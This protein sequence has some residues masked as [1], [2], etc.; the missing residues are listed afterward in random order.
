MIHIL[1]HDIYD[2]IHV[3]R[4]DGST[5]LSCENSKLSLRR[6][7]YTMTRI[8]APAPPGTSWCIL[9]CRA[10][11]HPDPAAK[12]INGT[13]GPEWLAM[14]EPVPGLMV[15]VWLMWCEHIQ[16]LNMLW[17][18]FF[19]DANRCVCVFFCFLTWRFAGTRPA[20]KPKRR[21]PRPGTSTQALWLLPNCCMY[22]SRSEW[23]KTTV[24]VQNLA[25]T[26][27][28]DVNETLKSIGPAKAKTEKK[29]WKIVEHNM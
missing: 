3:Y 20:S 14:L 21:P 23:L 24:V 8:V 7:L 15:T 9:D 4:N 22:E 5:R 12:V 25:E 11:V 26:L 1:S 27:L 18:V 6:C 28:S 2:M 16:R 13:Q 19:F 10:A 29:L 17:R